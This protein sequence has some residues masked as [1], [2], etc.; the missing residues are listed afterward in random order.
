MELGAT[1]AECTISEGEEF[2][3]NIRLRDVES[4]KQAG[5]RGAGIRVLVG[6]LTGS[7]R[8]SD[9]SP[10]GI[11]TMVSGAL[12]LA[13]ITTPDPHAGLPDPSDLGRFEGDLRLDRKSVV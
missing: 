6:N 12:N 1:G 4:L 8:T 5:S 11:E 3:V 2:S 9:L 7:S 13:R 10:Q